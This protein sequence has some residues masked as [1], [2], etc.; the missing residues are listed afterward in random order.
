MSTAEGIRLAER[1]RRDLSLTVSQVLHGYQ[2]D[3]AGLP[4]ESVEYSTSVDEEARA[5]STST[6]P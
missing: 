6:W 1:N 2:G 3:M 5:L 4:S